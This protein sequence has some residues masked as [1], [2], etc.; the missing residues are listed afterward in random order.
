MPR[1]MASSANSPG[2]HSV[3]GRPDRLGSSQATAIIWHTCSAL[4]VGGTPLRTASDSVCRMACSNASS[5]PAAS[6][7]ANCSVASNHRPRQV[8][9]VCELIF[10]S[11]A[12][13]V[14]RRPY[15]RPSSTIL[16]RMTRLCGLL[17]RRMIRCKIASCRSVT[18]SWVGIGP[19]A[20]FVS[21]CHN[22]TLYIFGN[23]YY[24]F[25]TVGRDFTAPT[26]DSKPDLRVYPH[27]AP[28]M[29]GC[30]HQCL[31]PP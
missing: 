20:I 26:A 22:I 16:V 6:I 3:I 14:F 27:P 28:H 24:T 2:V 18:R 30:F 9:T 29:I 12:M 17:D 13:V 1:L 23:R 31:Q 21:C 7:S 15:A 10:N 4:K 8:L 19:R 5:S 25:I 11:R